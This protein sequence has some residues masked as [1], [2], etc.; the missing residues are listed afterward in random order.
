MDMLPPPDLKN[1]NTPMGLFES[2]SSPRLQ[3]TAQAKNSSTWREK[4]YSGAAAVTSAN[5][6]KAHQV[7]VAVTSWFILEDRHDSGLVHVC[8]S[9]DVVTELCVERYFKY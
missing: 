4:S 8:F 7:C 5:K 3:L 1:T 6:H 9:T 2:K